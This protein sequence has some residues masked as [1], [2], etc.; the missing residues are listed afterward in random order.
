MSDE[1]KDFI[2]ITAGYWGRGETAKQA[3]ARCRSAGGSDGTMKKHGYTVHHV[4]VDT[5]LTD[6]GGL[7]YPKAHPPVKVI[8]TRK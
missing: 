7:S 2:C 6:G 8:D 1:R 3:I 4:H 5:N